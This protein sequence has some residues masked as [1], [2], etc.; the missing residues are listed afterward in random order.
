MK[1][2]CLCCWGLTSA[3]SRCFRVSRVL[4]RSMQSVNFAPLASISE[5]IPWWY[6]CRSSTDETSLMWRMEGYKVMTGN[7]RSLSTS[8]GRDWKCNIQ[9]Q[10]IVKCENN[11]FDKIFVHPYHYNYPVYNV[12]DIVFIYLLKPMFYYLDENIH[13]NKIN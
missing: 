6:F 3:E 5:R 2:S 4:P 1:R 11:S 7:A 12:K 8:V 9:Q 13:I 10:L